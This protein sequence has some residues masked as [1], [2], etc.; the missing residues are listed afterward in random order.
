MFFSTVN[1]ISLISDVVKIKDVQIFGRLKLMLLFS[2]YCSFEGRWKRTEFYSL[3]AGW[4]VT[5]NIQ[6]LD[7]RWKSDAWIGLQTIQKRGFRPSRKKIQQI[8]CNFGL[9]EF[10]FMQKLLSF[11]FELKCVNSRSE[12]CSIYYGAFQ[13]TKFT[14]V[15]AKALYI[16]DDCTKPIQERRHAL[17]MLTRAKIATLHI[18]VSNISFNIC[19]KDNNDSTTVKTIKILMISV[20]RC[21]LQKD[22]F[23]SYYW[24]AQD[25]QFR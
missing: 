16:S 2:E 5:R 3:T 23:R 21:D 18:S 9:C 6:E 10:T 17:R 22:W 20:C 25:S 11:T 4:N 24:F 14:F 19:K 15:M 7:R 13:N 8:A 12:T 1:A